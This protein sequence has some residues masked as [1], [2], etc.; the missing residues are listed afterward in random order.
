MKHPSR[1]QKKHTKKRYRVRDWRDYDRSLQSRGDLTLWFSEEGIKA[2]RQR[3]RRRPGGRLVYA[4]TAIDY[5]YGC[6]T[7]I[8][9][10]GCA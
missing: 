2:W 5:S 4:D 8:Y 10:E 9:I 6:H 1:R 7:P 3:G